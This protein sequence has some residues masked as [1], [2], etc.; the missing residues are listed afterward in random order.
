VWIPTAILP[1]FG[2]KWSASGDARISAAYGRGENDV[3]LDLSLTPEGLPRSVHFERWG[4][5]D[6]TGAYS[7]HPFGGQFT[8]Y[9][10]FDGLTIPT[11][12]TLGW[13]YG[14]DRWGE[15]RFFRF[16]IKD[17]RALIGASRHEDP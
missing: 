6:G 2:V 7:I 8:A 11:E 17:Y 15:G 13:H 12:G 9:A 3:T 14:T 4:D 16:A 10:T 1:R 5:P